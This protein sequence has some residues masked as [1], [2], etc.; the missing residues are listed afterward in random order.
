MNFHLSGLAELEQLMK[1]KLILLSRRYAAALRA[2]LRAG[3]GDH[4]RSALFVGR[5]AVALGVET[6][7]LAKIHEPALSALLLPG[8]SA[9]KRTL[10][11]K[12]AGVF[13]SQA[14]LPIEETHRLAQSAKVCLSQVKKTLGQRTQAL[15]AAQQK[16][17]KGV[18]LRR[19]MEDAFVT[20][21]R[22]HD[23]CL[24]ESLQLQKRLRQLTHQVITAQEHERTKISHELQDEIVQTLVGINVRLLSLK[25]T[26]RTNTKG[27]KN[28]IASTQ[29]LVVRSAKSVRQFANE[30]DTHS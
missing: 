5:Q 15:A 10:L 28:Q 27:L 12:R 1:H 13:F 30:L 17:Q 6:L 20:S 22:R 7:E 9:A 2:H 24:E 29:R 14:N 4:L 25:Q 21:G 23:Q 11:T 8:Y 3:V 19:D 18:L 26:A 16:L